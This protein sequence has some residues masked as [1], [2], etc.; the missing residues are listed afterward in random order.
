MSPLA[1]FLFTSTHTDRPISIIQH[2][3]YLP[4][5]KTATHIAHRPRCNRTDRCFARTCERVLAACTC[6]MLMW[7]WWWWLSSHLDKCTAFQQSS[8]QSS[9]GDHS[10]RLIDCQI[11][12]GLS[13]CCWNPNWPLTPFTPLTHMLTDYVL[14]SILMFIF[15]NILL[16][17]FGVWLRILG[18]GF[19]LCVKSNTI[20]LIFWKETLKIWRFCNWCELPGNSKHHLRESINICVGKMYGLKICIIYI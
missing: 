14:P 15:V 19:L 17:T 13:W 5:D 8:C 3:A 4:S 1:H 6:R 16:I 9:G 2:S 10:M 12:H 18:K 20:C 7:W 11:R